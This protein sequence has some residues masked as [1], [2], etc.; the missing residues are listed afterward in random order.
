[1][2]I[3]VILPAILGPIF[4]DEGKISWELNGIVKAWV[5][6]KERE[7]KRF[8]HSIL[9]WLIWI[10]VK[11]RNEE[12][13]ATET[14]MSVVTLPSQKLKSW[15]KLR[16][17]GTI[18]KCTEAQRVVAPQINVRSEVAT[19]A[20]MLVLQAESFF[21]QGEN[22]AIK[23]NGAISGDSATGWKKFTVRQW[24]ALIESCGVETRK[25]VQN[26][27]RQN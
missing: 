20:S 12:I 9:E 2:P 16:L 22:T 19:A 5:E 27:W 8:V 18:G 1:M 3:V 21:V 14:D 4:C 25:Q 17:E 15:Q 7:V 11:G 13:S 10:C 24:A 23:M 26:I 6:P